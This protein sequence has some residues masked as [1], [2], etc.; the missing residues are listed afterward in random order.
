MSPLTWLLIYLCM[1]F[2]LPL[3]IMP[4]KGKSVRENIS[5]GIVVS[6]HLE[7]VRHA[8]VATL[9]CIEKE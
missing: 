6:Q 4:L 8:V 1:I 7:S 5:E 3:Q 9:M 2:L